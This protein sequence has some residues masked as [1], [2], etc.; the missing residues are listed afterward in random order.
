[1]EA[2][3]R[4]PF[5]TD[6]FY[7]SVEFLKQFAQLRSKLVLEQVAAARGRRYTTTGR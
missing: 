3:T 4:K 1:M 2:D 7:E 6:A 5:S